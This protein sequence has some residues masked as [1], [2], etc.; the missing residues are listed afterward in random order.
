MYINL[1]SICKYN[2]SKSILN[3]NESIIFRYV[4]WKCWYFIGEFPLIQ[5]YSFV[6]VQFF[7]VGLCMYV[8]CKYNLIKR[9]YNNK[10]NYISGKYIFLINKSVSSY[11]SFR[12]NFN[13][14]LYFPYYILGPWYFWFFTKNISFLSTKLYR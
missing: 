1:Q 13:F 10:W 14:F 5:I 12:L 4:H 6:C 8:I 2:L 9:I 3:M 7:L 11:P